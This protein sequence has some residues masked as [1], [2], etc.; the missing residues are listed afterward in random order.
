MKKFVL[1]WAPLLAL[2][3]CILCY[4]TLGTSPWGLWGDFRFVS[5]IKD[6]RSL[7][8]ADVE[9][10]LKDAVELSSLEKRYDDDRDSDNLMYQVNESKPYSGWAKTMYDSGQARSLA[11]YKDGKIHGLITNWHANGQKCAIASM[12]DGE[13]PGQFLGNW[14]RNGEPVVPFTDG[15][16]T[17]W[18]D[19]GKMKAEW[20]FKDGKMNGPSNF[21]HE[22]G[23]KQAERVWKDD[24]LIS[25]KYWNSKGEEVETEEEAGQLPHPATSATAQIRVDWVTSAS[26]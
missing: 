3:L 7:R 8:D 22:N 10:L 17:K 15:L 26:S 9:E 19:N 20:T 18:H 2:S 13:V 5:K 4:I 23:Q 12:R 11:P 14:D 25:E 1:L 16:F 6:Q 24:E 21:W